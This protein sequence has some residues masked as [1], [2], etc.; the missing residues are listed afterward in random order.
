M[1]GVC[2][3]VWLNG[4]AT[5]GSFFLGSGKSGNHRKGD[6]FQPSDHYVNMECFSL[7]LTS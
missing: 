5:G 4:N 7:K 6:E 1:N 3:G 2:V